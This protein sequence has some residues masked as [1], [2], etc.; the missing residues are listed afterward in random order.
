MALYALALQSQNKYEQALALLRKYSNR[1]KRNSQASK[2]VLFLSGKCSVQELDST[3]TN[4]QERA[5]T[6]FYIGAKLAREGKNAMARERLVWVKNNANKELDQYLLAV[7]ELD[8]LTL[9][10]KEAGR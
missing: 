1:S 8:Q 9:N 3:P 6:N 5:L 4:D 7:I 2:I 10:P